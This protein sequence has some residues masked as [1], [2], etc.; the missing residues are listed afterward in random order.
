M[1]NLKKYRKW[2]SFCFVFV[3]LLFTSNNIW[4]QKCSA[5]CSLIDNSRDALFIT[6]EKTAKVKTEGGYIQEGVLLRLNNNSTCAVLVTTGSAEQFLKPIPENPTVLQRIRREIK[7]DLPDGIL[8][9]EVQYRYTTSNS[10]G[11]SV[12]GDNFYG[13]SLLGKRSILFEVPLK[14]FDLSSFNNITLI[15]QYVWEQEKRAKHSYATVESTVRFWTKE[16]PD[17][18]KARIR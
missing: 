14:H 2:P 17:E 4:S 9:P 12:G 6:Y 8:V 5:R 15:F 13:F 7:Y 1:R 16:L 11:L 3:V 18:V 10:S